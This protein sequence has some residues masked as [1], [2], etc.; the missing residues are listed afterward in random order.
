MRSSAGAWRAA[1]VAFDCAWTRPTYRLTTKFKHFKSAASSASGS[2]SGACD[3]PSPGA[4]PSSTAKSSSRMCL[5]RALSSLQV[6][7]TARSFFTA[8]FRMP[9][10]RT[11]AVIASVRKGLAAAAAATSDA[12]SASPRARASWTAAVTSARSA[13]SSS[14]GMSWSACWIGMPLTECVPCRLL[15]WCARPSSWCSRCLRARACLWSLL[16]LFSCASSECRFRRL[17][18]NPSSSSSSS[19]SSPPRKS[20]CVSLSA[21]SGTILSNHC[22]SVSPCRGAA[23]ATLRRHC[24]SDSPSAGS[25]QT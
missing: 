11:Q 23:S 4:K 6:A 20:V 7:T 12:T 24:S 8:R 21:T 19:E 3:R 18:P 25:Q 17:C 15:W 13:S 22:A 14:A 2:R 10:R 5:A 16:L 9:K 1:S